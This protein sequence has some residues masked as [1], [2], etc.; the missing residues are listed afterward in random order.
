MG[1][2]AGALVGAV[3]GNDECPEGG[4]AG[5]AGASCLTR[6]EAAAAGAI[7][8]VLLGGGI[9]LLIGSGKKSERWSSVSPARLRVAA[10]LGPHGRLAIAGVLS[11]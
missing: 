7:T 3:A 11:F 6:T 4:L 10:G 2:A 5:I 1:A 8:G 9:G